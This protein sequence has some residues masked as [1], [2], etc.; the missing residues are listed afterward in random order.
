V[1]LPGG[2][3]LT[4]RLYLNG[5]PP[6]DFLAGVKAR[7]LATFDGLEL[8]GFMDGKAVPDPATGAF[9]FP[10]ITVPSWNEAFQEGAPPAEWDTSI[11]LRFREAP[12]ENGPRNTHQFSLGPVTLREG[13]TRYIEWDLPLVLL[14][15]RMAG[16]QRTALRWARYSYTVRDNGPFR[17][18]G[19]ILPDPDGDFIV[20][21][22]PN[23]TVEFELYLEETAGTVTVQ[24]PA[25]GEITREF[26][27]P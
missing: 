22:P 21:L 1:T 6:A 12:G 8:F 18:N 10:R 5:Q 27:L 3:K 7:G 2:Y 13:Q 23:A 9:T 14:R 11:S 24:T 20:P 26:T 15:G 19:T 4:G 17:T 16:E 25:E